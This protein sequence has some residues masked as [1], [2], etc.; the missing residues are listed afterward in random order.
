MKVVLPWEDKKLL[1]LAA[2]DIANSGNS[3]L[4]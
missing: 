1:V 4:S 3:K 2:E